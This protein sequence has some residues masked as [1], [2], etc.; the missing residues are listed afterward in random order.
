MLYILYFAS[1]KNFKNPSTW[2]IE[3]APADYTLEEIRETSKL[4]GKEGF[5]IWNE[6]QSKTVYTEWFVEK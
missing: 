6:T 5:A 1:R 2:E 4:A 3:V